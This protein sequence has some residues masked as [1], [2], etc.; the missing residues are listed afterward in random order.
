MSL[1]DPV[2][3]FRPD[4]VQL[5]QRRGPSGVA[6]QLDAWTPVLREERATLRHWLVQATDERQPRI[7]GWLVA[8]THND[9]TPQ[10]HAIGAAPEDTHRFAIFAFRPDGVPLTPARAI[11]RLEQVGPGAVI[12]PA[13]VLVSFACGGDAL[14]VTLA[15]L[16]LE[17]WLQGRLPTPRTMQ[18][19][20]VWTSILRRFEGR[21]ADG[22]LRALDLA[23]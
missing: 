18:D 3:S 2:A 6:T 16:T 7:P 10:G 15:E 17:D 9:P 8:V 4:V 1:I 20:D 23:L 22:Q 11:Q 12:V 21:A 13:A 14:A 5:L 19:L